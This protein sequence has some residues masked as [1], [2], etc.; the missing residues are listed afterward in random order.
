SFSDFDQGADNFA[1]H[2]TQKRTAANDIGNLIAVRLADDFGGIDHADYFAFAIVIFRA[3]RSGERCEIALAFKFARGSGHRSF[4]ER[5]RIVQRALVFKWRQHLATP[6]AIAVR[7]SLGLPASVEIGAD[8]FC[9]D[10]A[11]RWRK[12]CI[13][14][15]LKFG[16]GEPGLG[17][18]MRDLAEGVYTGVSAACAVNEDFLL[19]DLAR[20]VGD[21][22]LNRRQARLDLPA[23]E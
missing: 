21:G 5:P 10:D 16:G 2:V 1:H 6:D 15:A 9:R 14:C 19:R 12:Q 17:S 13:Q 22:A 8:F 20:G 7:L 4:V 18:E 23:V 3:G 11:N